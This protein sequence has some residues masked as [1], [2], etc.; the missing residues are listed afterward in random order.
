MLGEDPHGRR[1]GGLVKKNTGLYIT[2]AL[3]VLFL[4]GAVWL[5][6]FLAWLQGRPPPPTVCPE[7]ARSPH[8]RRRGRC[9]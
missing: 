8:H 7:G 5:P 9:V 2:A 1:L 3:V 4:V 6:E